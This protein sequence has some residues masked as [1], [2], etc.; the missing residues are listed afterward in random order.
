MR[1]ASWPEA[2][3][4]AAAGWPAAAD[5]VGVLPGGRLTGEDAYAYGKFARAVLGTNDVDFRARP[6]SAEEGDVPRRAHVATPV[7]A[8]PTPTSSR[9]RRSCWSGFEPEEESPIVFLR[10]RKAVRKHGP[11]VFAVACHTTRGLWRSSTARC[12]ATVPG[13]E[14]GRAGRARATTASVA[15]DAGGVHPGRRA[16]GRLAG[17]A[18]APSR[19][20]PT[21]RR[22]AGLGPAPRR[23]A[24]RRRGRLLPTLLPGGRPVADAAARVDLAAAWGVD[25]LPAT[26]GRDTDADPR[27]RGQRQAQGARG[28]R[29]RL[30]DLPD[31]AP[32]APPSRPSA[33]WSASRSGP[34]R[35]P[36]APTSSARWPRSPRRPAPSSTGRAA[37]GRSSSVL[38]GG[39]ALTDVRVLAGI[40]EAMLGR[41]RSASATHRARPRAEMRRARRLGRRPGPSRPPVEP[42]P[43]AATPGAGEVVSH[44]AA[45]DRRRRMLDGEP[46]LRATGRSRSPSARRP[47]RCSGSASPR[48]SR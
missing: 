4:V 40:A 36:S 15:L 28:R 39:H 2:F 14:A 8:S 10:L 18:A 5:A 3:A 31:P 16:A 12:C 34:A 38:A 24:W 30:D 20:W 25:A 41:L 21:H 32:P 45:A 9:Q 44:L 46:Y 48:A 33:S 22:A 42:A 37:R 7:S 26:A 11:R 29:R 1:A 35:S 13:G 27:G 23:R 19:R 43:A 6:H 47:L 17:C